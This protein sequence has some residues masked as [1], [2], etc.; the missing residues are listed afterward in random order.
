[1]SVLGNRIVWGNP[2]ERDLAPHFFL[3]FF[4]IYIHSAVSFFPLPPYLQTLLPTPSSCH[5]VSFQIGGP[6]PL[7]A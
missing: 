2:Q 3:V 1:M 4:K 7:A 5:G 6:L